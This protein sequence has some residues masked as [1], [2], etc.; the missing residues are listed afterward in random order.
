MIMRTFAVMLLGLICLTGCDGG[1]EGGSAAAAPTKTAAETT[2]ASVVAADPMTRLAH[3]GLYSQMDPMVALRSWENV[4]GG[5]QASGGG[6]VAL[7]DLPAGEGREVTF[8]LCGACHSMQLVV[9]QRLPAHRWDELW[10]WMIQTQG[11]PDPGPEI[12]KQILTYLK[13]HFSS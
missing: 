10:T 3:K 1:D 6:P 12:Q 8:G 7:T 5:A 9:Q 13:Q 2:T 11:M 4:S